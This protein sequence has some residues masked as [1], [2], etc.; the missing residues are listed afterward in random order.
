[1]EFTYRYYQANR[2]RKLLTPEFLDKTFEELLP[3]LIKDTYIY[4]NEK[5]GDINLLK[6]ALPES[7]L[8]SLF[9]SY[10]KPKRRR[11]RKVKKFTKPSVKLTTPLSS[12]KAILSKCPLFSI[13]S[14][15]VKEDKFDV[16]QNRNTINTL[17][18]DPQT[19]QTLLKS[20]HDKLITDIIINKCNKIT[21]MNS[22][23]KMAIRFSLLIDRISIYAYH[24]TLNSSLQIRP[25]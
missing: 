17:A 7:E 22:I 16:A 2:F 11:I 4:Y 9:S 1:M 21:L 25:P 15:V 19:E 12:Y 13:F 3:S 23:C 20:L 8:L 5:I 24:K 18:E 6:D 10:E 14:E